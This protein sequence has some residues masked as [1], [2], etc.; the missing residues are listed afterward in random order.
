MPG[1][2]CRFP[3]LC[4]IRASRAI[5]PRAVFQFAVAAFTT[6]YDLMTNPAIVGTPLFGHKRAFTSFPNCCTLHWNHPHLS[7]FRVNKNGQENGIRPCLLL[8]VSIKQ[9][10]IINGL[11]I[12]KANVGKMGKI[13]PGEMT[14]CLCVQEGSICQSDGKDHLL[15]FE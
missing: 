4:R 1:C 14:P 5:P 9:I 8:L 15:F 7:L 12:V 6:L 2:S 10:I 13:V 3:F 11:P